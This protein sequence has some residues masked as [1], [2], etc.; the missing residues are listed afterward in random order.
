[1]KHGG[2]FYYP[3]SANPIP[4]PIYSSRNRRINRRKPFL[5]VAG[6]LIPDSDIT[7]GPIELRKSSASSRIAAALPSSRPGGS[8]GVGG[9]TNEPYVHPASIRGSNALQLSGHRHGASGARSR[10]HLR[11]VS[12]LAYVRLSKFL[13]SWRIGMRG[14]VEPSQPSAT[15]TPNSKPIVVDSLDHHT[16]HRPRRRKDTR[17]RR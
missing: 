3:R 16:Y 8:G 9:E 1:R 13:H 14:I 15:F 6:P 12:P 5:R 17:C 11:T 10:L 7:C 2:K 4:L